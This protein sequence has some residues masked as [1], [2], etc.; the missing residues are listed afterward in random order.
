MCFMLFKAELIES[1]GMP[2]LASF[3]PVF[4]EVQQSVHKVLSGKGT[5]ASKTPSSTSEAKM[6]KDCSSPSDGQEDKENNS[7]PKDARKSKLVLV[8]SGLD[9]SEQVPTRPV[10]H[11]LLNSVSC[12]ISKLISCC[13]HQ[14]MV[15]KFAK[16]V[17]A[18]VV[19]Q[20]TPEVT[21]VIMRTGKSN[22]MPSF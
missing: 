9:S 4:P 5:G 7:P 10:R 8:S 6:Q 1:G 16:R 3:F 22:H 19:S 11:C 17:G 14:I 15:K 2:V 12:R 18:R 20:V 13:C 21:H